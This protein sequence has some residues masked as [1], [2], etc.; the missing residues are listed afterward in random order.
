MEF[1]VEESTFDKLS[2]D[3]EYHI[4]GMVDG[5]CCNERCFAGRS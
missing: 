1:E 5:E 2:G 3:E 4:S